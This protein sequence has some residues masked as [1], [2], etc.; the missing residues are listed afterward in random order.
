MAVSIAYGA[1]VSVSQPVQHPSMV[2]VLISW[3]E[4]TA[5]N[6]SVFAAGAYCTVLVPV[7]ALAEAAIVSFRCCFGDRRAVCDARDF[8]LSTLFRVQW[9]GEPSSPSDFRQFVL[10]TLVRV[11]W[12]VAVYVWQQH[13]PTVAS[14]CGALWSL[15]FQLLVFTARMIS[16]WYHVVLDTFWDLATSERLNKR[17]CRVLLFGLVLSFCLLRSS[18]PQGWTRADNWQSVPSQ[19]CLHT[20]TRPM[21]GLSAAS[22]ARLQRRVRLQKEFDR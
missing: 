4:M 11:Q 1:V 2:Q 5:W 3:T 7:V 9:S 18:S 15:V 17:Q 8:L 19:V 13:P 16:L 14:S 6:A 10:S 22:L 12:S 21:C 20:R